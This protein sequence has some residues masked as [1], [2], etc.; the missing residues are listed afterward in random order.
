VV[1]GAQPVKVSIVIGK[2]PGLEHFVG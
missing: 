2:N 1:I